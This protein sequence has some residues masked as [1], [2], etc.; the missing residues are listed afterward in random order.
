MSFIDYAHVVTKFLVSNDKNSYKIRKK[1]GKKLHNLFLNNSF[2]NSITSQD[3]DKVIFNFSSHVLNTTEKSLLSK[4]LNF[5]IPPKNINY[6]DYMLHFELLYRDVDFLEVVNLDKEFIKSR[7]RDS[8]FSSY[9]D[10]GKTFEKNLPK[11]EFDAL[12]ILRKNKDIIVQ[13]ADKG[14][15]GVILNRKDYVCKMK[16][17]L[18]DS[19]KFHKVYIGHDKVLNHL[20][21]MESRETDVLKNLRDKKEISI[22]QYKDFSP[23]GSR[24]G[25][26]YGLAKVH[27]IV[28]DDLPS[29]RPILSAIGT[30][31]YKLAKF[32][33]PV[34]EHLTT[35]EY[36]IKDSFTFAEELQSF[37]SKLVMASFDIESLFANISLQET[38]DLCVESLFRDRTHVD[39]L[40]NDSFRELLTRTMSESL[41]LFDQEFYKQHDGVAMDSPLGSTLANVFL[42]YHEKIWL[43]NCPSEFKPVIYRKYVDDTFLLFRSKQHIEKFRNYL[44]RQHKNIKFTSETE[45]ENSIAFLDIKITRDNNKIMTSV[46]RKPTFS[47]VFTN[48]ESFIPKSYK[49]NLLFTLLHRAFKLGSYFERFH[50]EIDKL[51]TIFENNGYLKSFVDFCIKKYLDKV[52]IKKKVVLNASKKELICVL[53]FLGKRSM[54]LRTR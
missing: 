16:N 50:Q 49:Y 18:N 44:N 48:F 29:F 22:E 38:I 2:H 52:F 5:A 54:Q 9:K 51:K 53:P 1:Q 39:N 24:P 32:L 45:N 14:N 33:V 34:L 40:S 17:I 41:V 11:V 19:S 21:H 8:A 12:K 28:T 20:I 13:K 25:I 4:G 35:N 36:T 43:Q 47:G 3:P 23:S 15:T 30:S 37:D 42:C 46:Y 31:T 6:A 27:K 7:L 26:L 10:T